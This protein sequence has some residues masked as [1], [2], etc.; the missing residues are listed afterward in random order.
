MLGR[1]P[2]LSACAQCGRRTHAATAT[3]TKRMRPRYQRVCVRTACLLLCRPAIVLAYLVAG[4]SA[5]LSSLCY[6]EFSA[7]MPMS[8]G[9]FS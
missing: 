4:F 3:V 2:A 6:A 5:L 1:C 8:G 7:N 9:A